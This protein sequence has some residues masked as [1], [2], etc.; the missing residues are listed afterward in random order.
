SYHQG[1]DLFID[2]SAYQA[3]Y[4][5]A[6]AV[7]THVDPRLASDSGRFENTG[8]LRI[9]GLMVSASG[10]LKNWDLFG[11]YTWTDPRNTEPT[12]ALGNPIAGVDELRIGDVASHRL[13]L[14]LHTRFRDR[15]ELNLRTNYVGDRP[16]GDG[17]TVFEN[18]FDQ[19]DSYFVAHTTVSYQGL[20]PG[21]TWQLVVHNLFDA[22]YYHPGV[23][24]AGS[25]FAARLP[26]PGRAL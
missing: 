20:L 19:I 9:R 3:D 12:D 25:G 26:Q 15:W 6:V 17:T 18:P 5:D 1:E 24:R 4:S 13:N 7:R 23:Q 8:S 2:V 10:K 11:N 21:A 22:E 14:G 16:T